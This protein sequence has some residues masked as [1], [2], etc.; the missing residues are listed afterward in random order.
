MIQYYLFLLFISILAACLMVFCHRNLP[1]MGNLGGQSGPLD[2]GVHLDTGGYLDVGG[3]LHIEGHIGPP[4][5]G[6]Q[7]HIG[8]HSGPPDIGGHGSLGNPYG[9]KAGDQTDMKTRR[10]AE[11]FHGGYPADNNNRPD[12]ELLLDSGPLWE[13]VRVA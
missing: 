1:C 4:D 8:G 2:T 9:H 3:Q 5:I 12:T 11:S 6:G 7:L 13:V 10:S